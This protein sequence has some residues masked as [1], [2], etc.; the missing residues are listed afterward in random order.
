MAAP[1]AFHQGQAETDQ[2]RPDAAPLDLRV[3][4]NGSEAAGHVFAIDPD[5]EEL[6]MAQ[7][8]T[9]IMRHKRGKTVTI[10]G[11][12]GD[13]LCF[14]RCDKGGIRQRG[15]GLGIVFCGRSD[16]EIVH[17]KAAPSG[18]LIPRNRSEASIAFEPGFCA[19]NSRTA[20]PSPH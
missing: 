18:M 3:R 11:L 1:G 8:L 5:L 15:K 19:F 6:N 17:A 13:V 16:P 7:Y 2:A 10:A 12:L 4:R 9:I 14:F 20:W